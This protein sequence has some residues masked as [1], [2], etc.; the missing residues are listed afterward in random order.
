MSSLDSAELLGPDSPFAR[1]IAGFA[2]RDSQQQMATA[3]AE[4]S[5]SASA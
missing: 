3:V 2:P 5:P 1:E 4:R